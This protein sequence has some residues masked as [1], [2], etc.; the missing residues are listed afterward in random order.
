MRQSKMSQKEAELAAK[1]ENSISTHQWSLMAEEFGSPDYHGKLLEFEAPKIEAWYYNLNAGEK[2]FEEIDHDDAGETCMETQLR[3]A[4]VAAHKF[5]VEASHECATEV[6]ESR[7]MDPMNLTSEEERK[8]S[9]VLWCAH[10]RLLTALMAE[11]AQVGKPTGAD[12]YLIFEPNTAIHGRNLKPVLEHLIKDLSDPK[13]AKFAGVPA[14]GFD[15]IQLDPYGGVGYPVGFYQG[16]P[17]YVPNKDKYGQDNYAYQGSH[18]LLIR[19]TAVKKLVEYMKNHKAASMHTLASSMPEFI[20]M[21]TGATVNQN[22]PFYEDSAAS[23]TCRNLRSSKDKPD[24]VGHVMDGFNLKQ[25]SAMRLGKDAKKAWW[26]PKKEH[27]A[28]NWRAEAMEA[29]RHGAKELR[30]QDRQHIKN[31][32][33]IKWATQELE[34]LKKDT[35]AGNRDGFDPASVAGTP[36]PLDLSAFEG[37]TPEVAL[38][39]KKGFF[40]KK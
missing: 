23:L 18:A 6:D 12:Y 33:N 25:A 37:A 35:L 40:H 27:P 38:A 31:L 30:K 17:I 21:S 34:K 32:K 5:A 3:N 26:F 36:A 20:A 22:S 7:F 8:A 19:R 2:P 14:A 28:N 9:L 16:R 39:P 4:G 13:T 29:I 1:V 24:V 15:F 11:Q 10:K